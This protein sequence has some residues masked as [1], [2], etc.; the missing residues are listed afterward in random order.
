MPLK[1]L[2][3]WDSVRR[4]LTPKFDEA[5]ITTCELNL[6]GCKYGMFNSFAHSKKVRH[7]KEVADVYDV[8]LTCNNCHQIIEALGNKK[9]ITMQE[10]VQRVR[11]N[12]GFEI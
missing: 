8:I 9:V 3:T 4:E 1:S 12:R 7:W 6:P 5:G 11:E 2:P 10:V